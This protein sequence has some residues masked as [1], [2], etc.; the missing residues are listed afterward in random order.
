MA[1]VQV[2]G[3]R[4]AVY[5]DYGPDRVGYFFGLSLPRAAVCVAVVFP[6]F[7][8]INQQRWLFAGE[9]AGLAA[10]VIALVT[11][12]IRGRSATSWMWSYVRYAVGRA[13]GW[14]TYRSRPAVG[15]SVDLS[16][17]DLPGVMSGLAIHDGPP[18]GPMQTRLAI[19][20]DH[21]M[22]TWALT[23]AISHPG[24]GMAEG[25]VRD[26]YGRGLA[27]L[28]DVAARAEMISEVSFLVR[29]VPDD[30][31]ER[32]QWIAK[33]RR[34]DG[35][36]LSRRINDDLAQMLSRAAVRTETFVT[37]VIPEI[38][39]AKQAR[40]FG[41]GLDG[42]A[43]VLYGLAAE[44]EAML[45]GGMGA[46]DVAWLTSPQLAVAVRTG[47]APA[48]R[49]SIIDALAAQ[50]R[51]ASV[52]ADVPW[53]MAGPSGADVVMR[54]YSH[55]AWNSVSATV[56]L[57]D[58]GACLGALAPV[59]T[60]GE[61]GER[62]SFVVVYPILS[63]TAADRQTATG[64]FHADMAEGLRAKAG[65]RLR[66]RDRGHASRAHELDAK[67][68]SGHAL[69]R[70]Y[71]VACVT[72]PKTMRIAQFARQMDA[73]I[74]RAGFAPLRLDLAQDAGFAAATI[75]VGIGLARK[76]DQ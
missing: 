29:T 27:E 63:A 44:V 72:V 40:E 66:A 76:A 6:M 16:K 54:H 51:D 68:A 62:R 70:P 64:E 61:P 5:A 42:R 18:H 28:L 14:T 31:A 33:H 36:E 57:P 25:S 20:Q 41:G 59:L 56:K 53:A 7:V 21:T 30:G 9:L 58:K 32:E 26:R 10:V 12:P 73:S 17:A 43:R 75:P 1:G 55:D 67:L 45:R 22:R 50:Q 60:P 48:D 38:R 35:P 4:A 65:I 15:R 34:P 39:I 74:R 13:A 24:V 19:I 37:I 11:V 3:R 46:T 47:F 71:A 52:N 69:T 23:A 2:E 8:A 49:A